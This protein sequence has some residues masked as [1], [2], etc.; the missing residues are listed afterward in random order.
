MKDNHF[1]THGAR[2]FHQNLA[3][4]IALFW[5]LALNFLAFISP[6]GQ[7]VNAW[8]I[9]ISCSL[10]FR[11]D[12]WKKT[13]SLHQIQKR[14]TIPANFSVF[15]KT[16]ELVHILLASECLSF[17]HTHGHTYTHM[18]IVS[19]EKAFGLYQSFWLWKLS[20][21]IVLAGIPRGV[22]GQFPL[23]LAEYHKVNILVSSHFYLFQKW[24]LAESIG[25]K[26]KAQQSQTWNHYCPRTPLWYLRKPV[27]D[28]YEA[29]GGP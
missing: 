18:P 28:R 29:M 10:G 5:N 27:G 1:N 17:T 6:R 25:F 2:P 3:L 8:P 19:W 14:D 4:I 12:F 23:Q 21:H 11:V 20:N 24:N 13:N 26:N 16:L 9:R 22:E 15:S 7:D